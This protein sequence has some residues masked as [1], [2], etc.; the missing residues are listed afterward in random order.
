MRLRDGD[1]VTPREVDNIVGP[2]PWIDLYQMAQIDQGEYQ[3]HFIPNDSWNAELERSLSERLAD[4]LKTKNLKCV[5]T[6]YIPSDRG[7][8]FL[9]CI[10]LLSQRDEY[11]TQFGS[12]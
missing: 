5:P 4:R 1:I 3:F 12:Q 7:G 9:S 8:K 11:G 6:N 2:A 10:S